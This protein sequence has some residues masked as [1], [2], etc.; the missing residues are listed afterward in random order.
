MKELVDTGVPQ[1]DIQI[2]NQEISRTE[3]VIEVH[4]LRTRSMAGKVLVDVHVLVQ[5][6]LSVS[7][8]HHIG[9]AV[10]LAIRAALSS[11]SDVTVH[12]DPEDDEVANPSIDLP[13]RENLLPEL[14]EYW[15]GHIK[16]QDIEVINLHYLDGAIHIECFVKAGAKFDVARC[17]GMALTLKFVTQIDFYQS[18]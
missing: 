1:E 9:E 18:I 8:G 10:A 15:Q 16:K 12:I 5:P 14:F 3:G 7:E 4:Q 11:V 2:I 6:K 13:A 17:R